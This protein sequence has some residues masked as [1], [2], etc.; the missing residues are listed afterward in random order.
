ME[1]K[2]LLTGTPVQNNLTEVKLYFLNVFETFLYIC[3]QK[4]KNDLHLLT[5]TQINKSA[6]GA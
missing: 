5:S 1:F 6:L 3:I 4:Y 2:I